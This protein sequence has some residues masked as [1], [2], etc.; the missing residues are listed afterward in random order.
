MLFDDEPV[1]LRPRSLASLEKAHVDKQVDEWL[2]DGIIQPC[3]SDFASPV[4][5]VRKKMVSTGY[6]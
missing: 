1:S 3:E 6:A 5:V 2:R 4:T